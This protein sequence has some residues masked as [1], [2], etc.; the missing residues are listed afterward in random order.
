[1]QVVHTQK[2]LDIH[3]LFIFI[4]DCY[5][6][7]SVIIG[8]SGIT[9]L[10]EHTVYVPNLEIV[11]DSFILKGKD[12]LRYEISMSGGTISYTI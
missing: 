12:G 3:H 2:H 4:R 10:A 11:Y 9:S 1:M 6:D 7:Y 8:G 5:H